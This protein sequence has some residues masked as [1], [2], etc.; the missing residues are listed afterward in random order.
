MPAVLAGGAGFCVGA[1]FEAGVP[2][3]VA[4][5]SEDGGDGEDG[6]VEGLFPG[7]A[8]FLFFAALWLF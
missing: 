1:G 7:G 8:F 4:F 6:V 5:E 2:L 3:F